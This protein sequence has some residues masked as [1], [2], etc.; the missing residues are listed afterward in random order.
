[1]QLFFF[2][3][4]AS[5]N[6]KC[7]SPHLA[8]RTR[9][10]CGCFIFGIS[11]RS[12]GQWN[13]FGAPEKLDAA[14]AWHWLLILLNECCFRFWQIFLNFVLSLDS[15]TSR[16]V[17][18]F[19]RASSNERFCWLQL[20]RFHDE[21]T[22]TPCDGPSIQWKSSWQFLAPT[23]FLFDPVRRWTYAELPNIFHTNDRAAFS[24]LTL[25]EERSANELLCL[26]LP[27]NVGIRASH[28]LGDIWPFPRDC[29]F[30]FR[31]LHF[32]AGNRQHCITE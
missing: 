20:C 31:R 8:I 4:E 1:M 6:P 3:Q 5:L 32:A 9:V 23:W 17:A 13:I 26:L 24:E 16:L 7:G 25:T 29:G 10:S 14:I 22:C 19:V 27:P 12:T 2:R 18:S 11:F 15:T 30:S 28:Q 21:W